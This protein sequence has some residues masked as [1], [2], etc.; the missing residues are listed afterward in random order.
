MTVYNFIICAVFKN[1]AHIL[2]EWI[3]HYLNRGCDHIYL[4]N[5]DSTDNFLDICLKYSST[6]TVYN[7]DIFTSSDRR[8]AIYNKY[9]KPLLTLSKWMGIFDLS[10]FLYNPTTLVL[11]E[12]IEKCEDFSQIVIDCLVFGSNGLDKTPTSIVDSFVKR[13]LAT[14][15]N[16]ENRSIFKCAEL[17][18]FKK[19]EH[20]VSGDTLYIK[21]E[22]DAEAPDFIINNYCIQSLQWFLKVKAIRGSLDYNDYVI[23]LSYFKERDRNDKFDIRLREQNKV[24]RRAVKSMRAFSPVEDLITDWAAE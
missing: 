13:G 22:E 10:D 5:D 14:G 12:I 6:V 20:S 1:E 7:N 9:F 15:D 8:L 23:K 18:D 4:V 19:H 2:E 24:I 21:Y 17:L 11:P 16:E 3:K